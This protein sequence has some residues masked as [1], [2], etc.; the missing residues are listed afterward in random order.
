[1]TPEVTEQ[2]NDN[3]SFV[4]S[5]LEQLQAIGEHDLLQDLSGAGVARMAAEA[6][7]KMLA[8]DAAAKGG[9][10]EHPDNIINFQRR[11][12]YV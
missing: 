11:E 9:A 6:T 5:F 3:F 7:E 2:F 12:T 1:M 8:I 4:L 10:P